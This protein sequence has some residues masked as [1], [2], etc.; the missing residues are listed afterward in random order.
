M[1][2]NFRIER[3][4]EGVT[5]YCGDCRE[6]LP[7]LSKVDAVVTDIPYECSQDDNGLRVLDYGEWD[8][9][10]VGSVALAALSTLQ[11]VSTIIAFCHWNQ[12]NDIANMFRGRS[13]RPVVWVKSNPTVINGQHLFIPFGEFAYYGKL[14]GAWFGGNCVKSVWHGAAPH[15]RSHPTQKPLDLMQWCVRHV[16]APSSICLDPFMGSGTTGVAAVKLGRKFIGIE[17]EP[18]Y[19]D[20]ACRRIQAALDAPDLFIEQPKPAKQEAFL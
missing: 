17:I 13:W 8:G 10:G 9:A 7:T 12:L 19:F 20:I 18:K 14:P 4:A 11:Q 6:I 3:L 15:E 1:A 16:V 5:L 2:D